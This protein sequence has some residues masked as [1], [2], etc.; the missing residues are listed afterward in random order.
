[1]SCT[2][3]LVMSL[4]T[5]ESAGAQSFPATAVCGHSSILPSLSM[6]EGG[7]HL[8]SGQL[9]WLVSLFALLH[10]SDPVKN[11]LIPCSSGAFNK[12]SGVL[13]CSISVLFYGAGKING[14]HGCGMKLTSYNHLPGSIRLTF[15]L[16][17][18][19]DGL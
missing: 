12:F 15:L 6:Q 2:C 10:L 14:T 9:L 16:L 18:F 8:R 4:D 1:M 3:T 17:W 19:D 5:G 13:I 7:R 11:H